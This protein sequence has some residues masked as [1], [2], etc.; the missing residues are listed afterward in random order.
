MVPPPKDGAGAKRRVVAY[1][2]VSTRD[3][4]ISGL[5]LEAQCAEIRRWA[6]Q[7]DAEIAAVYTDIESGRRDDRPELLKALEHCTLINGSLI[8]SRLDRLGR[9]LAFIARL[10]DSEVELV[11]AN[12]PQVTRLN[13]PQRPK[14]SESP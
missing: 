5:G 7:H 13:P 11:V 4:G 9:R 6:A 8:V 3:Q 10:M 2:R 12:N 14:T 1:L